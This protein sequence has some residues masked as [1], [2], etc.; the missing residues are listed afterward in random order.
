MLASYKAVSFN[1]VSSLGPWG[2]SEAL[3]MVFVELTRRSYITAWAPSLSAPISRTT[4]VH[5][6]IHGV[7]D[8]AQG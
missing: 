8:E 5:L 1:C 3:A 7:V 6:Y 2:P 4:E